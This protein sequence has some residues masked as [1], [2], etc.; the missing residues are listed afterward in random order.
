MLLEKKGSRVD[1]GA[2]KRWITRQEENASQGLRVAITWQI[3]ERIE[4]SA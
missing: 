3:Q 4:Q 1:L 2:D